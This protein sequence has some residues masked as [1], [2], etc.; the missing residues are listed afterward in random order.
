MRVEIRPLAPEDE[1]DGFD[2]GVPPLDEFFRRYAG[3]NQFRHHIGVTH[4]AVEGGRILGYA[5]ICAGHIETE[6][7]HSSLRRRLPSYP[8]PILRIARLAVDR[9]AR[10]K[11]IGGLL[12]K[13]ALQIA[14]RMHAEYGCV[15]VLLDAKPDAVGF[16]ERHGF[17]ALEVEGGALLPHPAPVVMFLPLSALKQG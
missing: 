5:T 6:R 7:L 10:K 12:L 14:L 15:G 16:Y 11:G 4:V 3:Q 2:S 9:R 8:L 17:I 13:Y 1:R